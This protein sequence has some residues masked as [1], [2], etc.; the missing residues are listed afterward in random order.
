MVLARD[1]DALSLEIHHRVVAAVVAEFHL[2]GLTAAG[3][4]H[5]LMPEADTE[6]GDLL[7]KAH[8]RRFDGVGAGLGVTGPVGEEDAVRI[9]RENLRHGRGRGHHGHFHA[10]L[11]H[12]AQNVALDAEVVGNNLVLK[13]FGLIKAGLAVSGLKAPEAFLPFVRRLRGDFCRE[14]APHHRAP[15]GSRLFGRLNIGVG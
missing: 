14:I 8:A 11:G 15:G 1:V 10:A 9:H 6:E 2:E 13:G 5:D 7:F 12:L 3:K 4:A